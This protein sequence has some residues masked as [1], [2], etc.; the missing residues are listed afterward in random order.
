M[1]FRRER[2]PLRVVGNDERAGADH[3]VAAGPTRSC[4]SPLRRTRREATISGMRRLDRRA[5]WL[6]LAAG[7]MG[8][9]AVAAW[10]L[11]GPSPLAQAIAQLDRAAQLDAQLE[12]AP[13]PAAL[14]AQRDQALNDAKQRLRRLLARHP[15]LPEA[16]LALAQAVWRA[17]GELTEAWQHVSAAIDAL[18]KLSPAKLATRRASG[19]TGRQ[20]LAEAYAERAGYLLA[21]LGDSGTASDPLTRHSLS[22]AAADLQ[23]AIGLDPQPRYELMQ[24]GLNRLGGGA[25]LDPAELTTRP[26]AK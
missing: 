6:L 1:A 10:R 8:F 18:A 14:T 22:Q 12:A 17:D 4:A 5:L 2:Y 11:A 26:V 13:D 7:L 20:V 19:R 3:L 23:A 9:V 15:G 21:R 16:E 25:P 24:S